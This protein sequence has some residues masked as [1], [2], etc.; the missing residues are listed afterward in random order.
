MKIRMAAALVGLA[1]GSNVPAFTQQKDT[2]DGPVRGKGY[3]GAI[4]VREGDA[5]M[6]TWN[7]TAAQAK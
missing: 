6:E 5:W 2:V 1:F 4:Y 7:L 3:Y